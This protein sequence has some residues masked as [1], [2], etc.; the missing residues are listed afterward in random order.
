MMT[1]IHWA[2]EDDYINYLRSNKPARRLPFL[3]LCSSSTFDLEKVA[4][5]LEAVYGI[6]SLTCFLDEEDRIT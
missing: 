5:R 1:F 2:I 4:E 6:M 3:K